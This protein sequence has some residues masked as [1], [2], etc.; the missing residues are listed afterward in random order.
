MTNDIRTKDFKAEPYW[1][2]RSPRPDLGAPELPMS[3]DVAVIGSGYTGL[4]AALQVARS[5][6]STLVL[7]A[8]DAGWGCSSRNG[9]Q[10]STSI[11]PDYQALAGKH[12]AEIAFNIIK[13]GHNSLA[14]MKDFVADEAIDCDFIVPGRFHAAHNAR[15]YD[16]LAR[17]IAS[18]PMG[19]EVPAHMVPRA[20]QH[21]E[22]GTDVYHG[23][24]VMEAH[25]S[26]D[27][28]RYHQGL[29]GR[30]IAAGATVIP[31]CRVT[32]LDPTS[33]GVD[34]V[35][36]NGKARARDVIVAT[37]GYTGTLTPWLRRRV[38]PIGSYIIATEPLDASVM[39]RLF[40]T[41]RVVSD[42][43]K[44]VYYYRPSPDRRRI[45]FGGRVTSGE[46]SPL[47]SGGMLRDDLIGIFPELKDV[48]ISHSWMG[49]VAYTFDELSHVGKREG[50]HYAMGYCGSGVGMASYLGTRVGQQVLGLEEGRTALDGVGF[51]TRPLYT[52][53]PWFLPMTVAYYRWRDGAAA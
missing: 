16:A 25:A 1:W 29:L 22:L 42:T 44:V 40:P 27:P 45:I 36:A 41:R 51:Q 14:F 30:V 38:I 48:R 35:T 5:G 31:R 47:I 19:L 7:D 13:E 2:D 4:C 23:G 49:F 21:Q 26:L 34:V 17:E 43:R 20:E 18:A 50:M 9:G 33:D 39:D 10:I 3:V 15:E 11:K 52:G 32:H 28:G 8:E 53:K 46:T 37:N 24:A 6:R 12:G